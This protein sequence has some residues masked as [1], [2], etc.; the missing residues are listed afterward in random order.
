MARAL[1]QHG[2]AQV[3]HP[4]LHPFSHLGTQHDVELRGDHQSG[5]LDAIGLTG[6]L[7]PAPI[8]AS[9]PVQAAAKAAL[10]VRAHEDLEVFVGEK[11][12]VRPIRESIE[13][14]A[15]GPSKHTLWSLANLGRIDFRRVLV[16]AAQRSGYVAFELRFCHAWSLEVENIMEASRRNRAHR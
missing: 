3:G 5:L 11:F 16:E 9:I 14:P 13:Q 7:L 15:A 4:G 12:S 6:A 10:L 8:H 2:L 1:D